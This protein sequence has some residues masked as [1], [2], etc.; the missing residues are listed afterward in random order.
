MATKTT[1][2]TKD[3]AVRMAQEIVNRGFF[4]KVKSVY[5]GETLPADY[6][7][8]G[9]GPGYLG[10]EMFIVYTAYPKSDPE[11]GPGMIVIPGLGIFYADFDDEREHKN[12]QDRQEAPFNTYTRQQREAD[13]AEWMKSMGLGDDD[14]ENSEE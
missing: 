14:A 12:W 13:V 1:Y 4:L 3:E 10:D 6:Q 7:G 9:S 11:K 2:I 8:S 5:D